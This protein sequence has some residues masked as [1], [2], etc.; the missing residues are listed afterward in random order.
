M[1][2]VLLIGVV[3]LFLLLGVGFGR[4]YPRKREVPLRTQEEILRRIAETQD[5]V[6]KLVPGFQFYSPAE[7]AKYERR[8]ASYQKQLADFEKRR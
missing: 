7:K 2:I 8:L 3:L 5:W 4:F 1:E 6:N